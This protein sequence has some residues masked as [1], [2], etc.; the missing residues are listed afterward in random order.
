MGDKIIYL[1]ENQRRNTNVITITISSYTRNYFF[2]VI[3]IERR[4]MICGGEGRRT[5]SLCWYTVHHIVVETRKEWGIPVLKT[6]SKNTYSLSGMRNRNDSK[7]VKT[8]IEK[9]LLIGWDVL[10]W[11]MSH[12]KNSTQVLIRYDK[13]TIKKEHTFKRLMDVI[14]I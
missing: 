10:E 14:F 7:N 3:F 2:F 5:N 1:Y 9:I 6:N 12:M 4:G 8:L 11:G 13:Y